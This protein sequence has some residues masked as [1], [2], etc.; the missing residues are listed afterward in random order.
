MKP[1]LSIITITFNAEKYLERTIQSIVNQTVQD[2]EYL[3]IDGASKDST[4][5]II[6][7]YEK[8]VSK[9]ISEPD[10]GLYDAMNKGLQ[11]ATGEYVWFM[12]A[13]DEI[14]DNQA[15][16]T[17]ISKIHQK[18]DV[19]YGDAL[20]VNE[21]G[22]AVG[23]R[24]KVTPHQLP[25]NLRWQHFRLGMVVCHQ[26]FIARRNIAPA[27]LLN[28]RYCADIDWEIKCLKVSQKVVYLDTP[29]ARYLTG[30]YSVKN[31]KK[32]LKDRFEV[33]RTHFGFWATLL[34]HVQILFRG[35]LFALKRKGKY[36]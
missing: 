22:S 26:S 27:Y 16:E 14:F 9:W 24:S 29:L 5:D 1:K 34:A 30:G 23:L 33:L 32:S 10:K 20:F 15:V 17:F 7:H 18:G 36:W 13:G 12:N 21:D 6:R 11:M 4:I 35:F 25:K 28:H 2:F 8:H 3:I 31:L 19:Y